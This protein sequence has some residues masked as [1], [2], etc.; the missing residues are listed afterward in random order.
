MIFDSEMA[1]SH[2][3]GKNFKSK[4]DRYSKIAI[5]CFAVFMILQLLPMLLE[6]FYDSNIDFH[7][8]YLVFGYPIS[9]IIFGPF[10]V[11]Y[12]K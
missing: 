2:E 6:I 11:K 8:P 7:T 10:F 9:C 1:L 5:A 4:I 3:K 12:L